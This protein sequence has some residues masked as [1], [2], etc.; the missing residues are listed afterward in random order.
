MDRTAS[1][2]SKFLKQTKGRV[3]VAE[4]NAT[5][6]ADRIQ[7]MKDTA[8]EMKGLGKKVMKLLCTIEEKLDKLETMVTGTKDQ[9]TNLANA[10]TSIDT[11][12]AMG[13]RN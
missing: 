8:A 9:A 4:A 13:Q 6:P 12:T 3:K 7:E 5:G 11:E 2:R 1:P 10:G